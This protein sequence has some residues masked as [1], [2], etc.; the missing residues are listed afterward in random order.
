MRNT[1]SYF[2]AERGTQRRGTMGKRQVYLVC[3]SLL[4]TMVCSGIIYSIFALYVSQLGA[5][6]TQIGTIYTIGAVAGLVVAPFVGRLSDRYGRRPV[7]LF[8]L[9]SLAAV[10]FLYALA[11]SFV[12]I[13]P[14]Q[15]LEGATWAALGTVVPALVADLAT[16]RERG[17]F[18]GVYNQAWY[19][20]WAI[21]PILGGFLADVIGFRLTF[22]ACAVTIGV[23]SALGFRFVR[24]VRQ[25]QAPYSEPY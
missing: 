3:A 6:V 21:G 24:D 14:V 10:F 4:P 2:I 17:A 9:F 23:G 11:T 1:D 20:G 15:A 25:E 7:I 12:T 19:L 16:E 18:M 5:S 8:C 22:V 13:L